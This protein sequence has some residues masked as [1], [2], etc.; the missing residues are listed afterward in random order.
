MPPHV[1]S[2]E[3]QVIRVMENF[4]KK[5][6]DMEKYIYLMSLQD[7]NETLFYRVVIDRYRRNDAYC[8]YS[9]SGTGVS[10]IWSH[11]EEAP[12]HLHFGQRTGDE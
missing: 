8:L 3:T 11:F 1:Q 7:R 5:P 2:L 12:G 10:G 6:T 9:H 4:R